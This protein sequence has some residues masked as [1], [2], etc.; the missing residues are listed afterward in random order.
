[1]IFEICAEGKL[2]ACLP[3]RQQM[4]DEHIAEKP[5]IALPPSLA[6]QQAHLGTVAIGSCRR[7]G[8]VRPFLAAGAGLLAE[9]AKV[10]V[11]KHFQQGMEAGKVPKVLESL[12][13]LGQDDNHHFRSRNLSI[14]QR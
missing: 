12:G 8:G 13:F 14:S 10:E 7:R 11:V 3:W 2:S 6:G 9:R 4:G 5:H 1:M